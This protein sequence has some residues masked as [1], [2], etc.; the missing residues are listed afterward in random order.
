MR[1]R[2]FICA[3]GALAVGAMEA[4]GQSPQRKMHRVGLVFASAPTSEMLGADPIVPTARAF[5]HALRDL[6][7]VEG[8]NVILDRRSAEGNFT[9]FHGVMREL[10]AQKTDVIVT[11]TNAATSAAKEVTQTTPIVMLAGNPVQTGLVESLARPGGN[12]TGIASFIGP[13]NDLFVKWV[14]LL[15]EVRPGLS[16]V[17]FLQS[18]RES[19]GKE[20]VAAA[21][22]EVHRKLGVE[23]LWAEHTPTNY[24]DAFDFISKERLEAVVVAASA[25]NFG[26]RHLIVEL[27]RQ[28]G[29]LA[30][31]GDRAYASLGGLLA[32]GTDGND[33]FRRLAGYVDRILKGAKPADLPVE[34]QQSLSW[35]SISKPRRRWVSSSLRRYLRGL[36][37]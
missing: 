8:D 1:R 31:Y 11:T 33:I 37:R 10:V 30:T 9:K 13:G 29:L 12:V 36:M 2:E 18:Q 25:A 34:H 7:Y 3:L 26:N 16:R 4:Q 20:N 6:G 24:A 32:Y 27:V 19:W 23:M 17:A 15:K 35:S 21:F 28:H 14:Q 5:V 22:E